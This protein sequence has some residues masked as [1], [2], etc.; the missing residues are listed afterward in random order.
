MDSGASRHMT[1]KTALLY[2]VRNINGAYVGFA[3]NQGGRIIGEGTLSN[4]I[5]T[6]ERVNYIAELEINLLSISQICD[7]MYTTHFTDKEC[8]ILKPG[9]VIPEEW[10][11]MRAPRVNDLYVLDMS[12][13]T[14]TT[15]QAHCFVS[16]AT[17]KE[18]RLWHRKMGHIP[19][20]KMNHLVHNDL[21]P[22]VH[23]KGFNLEGEC[24]SCVKGKQKKKSHPT[25][26]V[27]SVSRPLER[28]HMD[29]FGPVNVK[30]ITGDY[31]CLVVTDD[32]SRFSWV[33]FLK[34]KDETFDSLMALFKRIENLYQRRIKRIRSDNG[35]E[36][37]NSKMEEFCDE[38]GILH[39][40]SAPYTPQQNGVA[41]RKNWTLI[42]TARTMLADSKLPIN[43][44]A[45]AVSAACYTLNRVLTVK[46]FNKTFFEL[47]NNRKPNLK[48][49]EPF[50]SPCTVIE[51]HGKFGPKCIEGIFVGYANPMRRVFVPSEK[52]IIEAANVECQ[53][54]TMPPQNP[55]DSWRYHYDKLWD[56]FDMREESEEDE[57][58]FDE[59][60][61]LREYESQQRFPAE[62]SRRPRETANDDEAGPSN[63]GEHDDEVAP[64]NQSDQNDNQDAE[65][66]PV[67]DHGDSDSEGEHIQ[68]SS[69]TNQVGEQDADQNVTNLEGNVDVPREVMPRTLSYHPEELIIGEL[70]SGV[71]TRRQI[72]QGLTCFYSTVAPLQT[73]FSL[74]CF[75][76]QIELRTYKEALTEDSWVIAMQKEL[77]QF[78][79]LGVWKLVD[80][81]DGHRKINTKWVFKCKRDDR[82]VVVRNKA[83]LVVQ[84]FS[85][86]EGIDFTEV[87]APVARL[88]AI[89]IFLAFASWK[90]FK[91]YQLDVKSAFL[92]GK[93]KEE[94]YVV[95]PPG[96]TDPIH[97]NKVYLL[98]KALYGLHQ[99]PRA[100]Y[101]TMSQHLLANKFIRGKVD[102]TLFTK[103][104]DGHLLIVQIYVDDIIFGSTNES[105]CKD[106]ESVMKQKFEMSS[107]GEMKFFLGLQVEQLPEGIFIHQT[108]YVRDILEK[109]GMSSSTPAATPLAT[110]HGIHP[111]LTGDRADETFYRS[112]IG[113]LMYL[114]A[115]RHDIMYPTCLVARYQSNPR[116]SHMI[117]VKRI[118]RYLKGTSSLGLWY[119]RKGDFT[120]EGYSDSDF[121][122][123]KVNTKS[124]T[125]GC[126][127]FGPR[128]VTWQCKKQTSVALS[129]C[130]AEYVSAS[131]CCSQILWIQQ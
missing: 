127:F 69:Q 98:D 87:Y 4:G 10:I 17:E 7:R 85:Q 124:K 61:I 9:F 40:F 102:A 57:D 122:C 62:Y 67:F 23:V 71:R 14:T 50:G 104:V 48:Y 16:R 35:T 36:F 42:E 74:S 32:Y 79:K 95:Q 82:G 73:E 91:V 21:V 68:I 77:S 123:C 26:Q 92:Y 24:I 78:E 18:S 84:G 30:S 5:V 106:F 80:F 86:Q 1:G 94:V 107:M 34:T 19:L 128:L 6:F 99:A 100:W 118:L 103:E 129:T 66:M 45:E 44:W 81:P 3:G 8:L 53:G 90:N 120:L 43:F 56:S 25:K 105:L 72:D 31:Y 111:D 2:D 63:A 12:V 121:G 116:A 65:N 58:F 93:V 27:N 39:E 59:L 88:E 110:N 28:L 83:R 22:G 96:F 97:K 108:K 114:I 29:L 11:I 13:A 130:E 75:I 70:H 113:S 60:D 41:E 125:S 126:Q 117:I 47:I 119:P 15:G 51:P 131:S 112:M 115:S 38:K 20:R 52:R 46:K 101:E 89:R 33:S 76:S 64:G 54:Y 37:K 109:F 55:G 49:L